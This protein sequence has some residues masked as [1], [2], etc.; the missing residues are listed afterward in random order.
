[1][2]K[3]RPTA[4]PLISFDPYFSVWSFNDN[5]YDDVTRHWSGIRNALTGAVEIDDEW[6]RFMGKFQL[7]DRNYFVEPKIIE[8]SDLKIFATKT[9][10][11]FE[12]D[13]LVLE[14]CF[15]TPNLVDDLKLLSK[16]I[17]YIS[18]NFKTKDEKKHNIKMHFGVCTEIC[19]DNQC[20]YV[21]I[22]KTGY[23]ISC[24]R[25]DNKLLS[26]SGDEVLTECGYFH[27]AQ[28]DAKYFTYKC[29][30]LRSFCKF[31]CEI[32]DIT[33]PTR[34]CDEYPVMSVTK[35]YQCTCGASDFLCVGYNETFSV[36]YFGEKLKPYW[37][38][39]YD[40]FEQVLNSAINEYELV[41]KKCDEFDAEFEKKVIVQGKKYRD[42]T[43]LAYRQIIAAHKLC[44]KDGKLLYFSKENSSNGCIATVDITYP[45]MPMYLI[46]NTDLVEGMLRPIFE[47]VEGDHDWEY[48][49]APHDVGQYP[50][51][52]GQMYDDMRVKD[53]NDG[54]NQMPV[55]ECGNML[56]CVAALCKKKNE[57]VFAKEHFSVLEKW[58]DYLV[59]IGYDPDSQLCTDDFAGHLAHNANLAIKGILGIAAWGNILDNMGYDGKK[60]TEIAKEYAGKWK[61]AAIDGDH[62]S[63]T[64]DKKGTWSIKYNLVWDKI[65][66][67]NVFDKDIY[68]TE[69]EYYKTKI[70]RYGIPLDCR[71]D[72]TKSDWQMWSTCLTE[73]KDYQNAI[74]DAM[75]N[76]ICDIKERVPFSDWYNT[77]ESSYKGFQARSVQGGL[78]LPLLTF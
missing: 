53:G 76:M 63:L 39:Y 74:I 59:K 65:L 36:E 42:I 55:E 27:L 18:Y 58:A 71:S 66:E 60:Y 72:Y 19:S 28:R 17:S 1:M 64:F 11:T 2:V 67:L 31:G 41:N 38:K 45:T 70:N 15:R 10:Y 21:E 43:A 20:E 51:A 3:F 47:F 6:Y 13:I 22:K 29:R 4:V 23:S 68:D 25:T 16:P 57:Y 61:K 12:N 14:V 32:P 26:Q 75:W 77:S 52:N 9:V 46:M 40:S 54:N 48:E 44:E 73:D 50:V 49:F 33:E 24:G 8:Q 7:D 69:V 62:Y 30:D 37:T 78:F 56:L 35:E 34:I 5:L